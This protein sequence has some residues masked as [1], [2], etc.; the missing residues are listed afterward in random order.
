MTRSFFSYGKKAAQKI[1]IDGTI[2]LTLLTRAIQA[3]GT[4]GVVLVIAEF[5]S[6]DLQGYYYT[7]ASIIAIQVF[8]ELG[9]SSIIT[10]FAAHEFAHV[11]I[12]DSFE[13]SG[14]EYHQSRLASLLH[15]CV[16]W[17][18]IVSFI[19]FF[20]LLAAGYYFFSSYNKSAQHINWQIP[21][22]ILSLA[23]S[24]NLLVDP[25]LAFLDGVGRIHQMSK[26]RLVQKGANVILLFVL[27]M[28][29]FELYSS[30]VASCVAVLLI[31]I[32]LF[33]SVN[34]KV[35]KN[36]W[37]K[38]STWVI[39]YFDEIFPYQWRIAVSWI[40]GYFIFQLFTPV[41]FATGGPVV[42]GQMGMTI[43][44]LSG[45]SAL[46]M[47]WM[48]TKIPVFSELISV[49][50]YD[51]L[52][53]LF[54]KTL[55]NLN[56]V[57]NSLMVLF[58]IFVLMLSYFKIP[59]RLRLLPIFPL[60]CMLSTV[61]IN[62]YIFSWAIY[63]RCHKKEPILMQAVVSAIFLTFSTIVFGKLYGL[64]GIVVPYTA[65]AIVS[66]IWVYRIFSKK[67]K[68]WH[69]DKKPL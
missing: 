45:V 58:V 57:N 17:F 7:F 13:I 14:D 35:L 41:L 63:L 48:T 23:T 32:L 3:A 54:N 21:W 44:I 31:Y 30:A 39:N 42:S 56:L 55:K 67:R 19:L 53:S 37:E 68:E 4:F 40:S 26:I 51:E 18:A 6:S 47:S 61:V 28:C 8:F 43:Q 16:K 46:S 66:L 52:D 1:G 65:W 60:L 38:K 5:L 59:L 62:Q 34:F 22:A 25:T 12:N 11:S 50:K 33:S 69:S 29:G 2:G 64:N 20:V 10:Q 15:F 49:K 36:I 9:L 27:L 24:L